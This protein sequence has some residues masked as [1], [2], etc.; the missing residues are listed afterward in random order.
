MSTTEPAY[1][2]G[3]LRRLLNSVVTGLIRLGAAPHHD[4]LLTTVGRRS[5]LERTTPVTLVEDADGR[6]LVAPYGAV[7]WVHNARAAG[8]VRLRRGR[9]AETCTITEVGPD[10]A[11]PVLKAYLGEVP[12]VRPFFGVGPDAS[13]AEFEAEAARH[14]VF[15]V[16]T[17]AR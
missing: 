8:T 7:A 13:L 2:L 16:V 10:E 14:P 9:H 5:G 11:A 1:H 12:I 15:R 6:W 3:R 17:T 4:V